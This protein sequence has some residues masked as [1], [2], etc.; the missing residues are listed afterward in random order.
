MKNIL[1]VLALMLLAGCTSN[2]RSKWYGGNMTINLPPN[3]HLVNASWKDGDL[4]Y[5]YRAR[6]PKEVATNYTLAENSTYGVLQGN[7][8]FVEK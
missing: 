4:W 5:L 1:I 7:V 3:T 8:F 6:D 2:I